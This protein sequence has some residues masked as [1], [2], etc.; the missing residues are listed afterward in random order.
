MEEKLLY[1][2]TDL[3][4]VMGLSKATVYALLKI[5]GFPVIQI[6]SKKYIPVKELNKWISKNTGHSVKVSYD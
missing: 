5:D 1:T 3:M 2:P 4:T 6:N